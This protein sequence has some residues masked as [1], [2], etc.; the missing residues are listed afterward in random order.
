MTISYGLWQTS[1]NAHRQISVSNGKL[2]S[3]AKVDVVYAD[4]R[5]NQYY[6][7]TDF[8]FAVYS[9]KKLN[10]AQ[11]FCAF[12]KAKKLLKKSGDTSLAININ[13]LM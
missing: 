4:M 2:P 6:G 3:Y 5:Y 11:L 10:K 7:Y 12:M 9:A 1:K 8:N 13:E